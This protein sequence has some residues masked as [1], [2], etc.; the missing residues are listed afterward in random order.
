[1]AAPL[2]C[3]LCGCVFD[4]RAQ[5]CHPSCPLAN[6]CGMVCCPRCGYGF[7]QEERGL[8]GVIKKAL[9]CLGRNS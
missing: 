8:A 7:P 1:M 3:A 6:G 4:P 9:V 2:K 5:G